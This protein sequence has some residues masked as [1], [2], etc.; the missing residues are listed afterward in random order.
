MRIRAGEGECGWGTA[1][2]AP[3]A[4]AEQI[5]HFVRDDKQFGDD[6]NAGGVLGEGSRRVGGD[7]VGDP[8]AGGAGA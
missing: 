5:P 2:P 3:T 7:V 1:N 8:V 6:K 4:R